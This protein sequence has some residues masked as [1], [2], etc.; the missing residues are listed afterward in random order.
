MR[1]ATLENLVLRL[2]PGNFFL[3]GHFR[4]V[5]RS[6]ALWSNLM[7]SKVRDVHYPNPW[8]GRLILGGLAVL[9][10]GLLAYAV[11]KPDAHVQRTAEGA[12]SVTQM[13]AAQ[14]SADRAREEERAAR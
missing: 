1:I 11:L 3:S 8:F 10:L 6:Q 5:E 2:E 13:D 9:V 7:I 4:I 14:M 12:A